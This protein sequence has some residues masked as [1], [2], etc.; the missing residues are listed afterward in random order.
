M[1]NWSTLLDVM[2]RNRVPFQQDSQLTDR[3]YFLPHLPLQWP[4]HWS[5]M[6]VTGSRSWTTLTCRV[7]DLRA[8]HGPRVAAVFCVCLTSCHIQYRWPCSRWPYPSQW[9]VWRRCFLLECSRMFYSFGMFWK[10]STW[11]QC[12]LDGLFLF[13]FFVHEFLTFCFEYSFRFSPSPGWL[14]CWNVLKFCALWTG[15]QGHASL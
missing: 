3:I 1:E 6:V 5:S 8:A 11:P 12:L 15:I 13:T 9:S 7:V 4:W 10:F 2:I 14:N